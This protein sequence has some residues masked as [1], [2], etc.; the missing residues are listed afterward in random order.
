MS[1]VITVEMEILDLD[2]LA[3][4][5][6]DIGMELVRGQKTYKWW[7]HSVGDY[8]IPTGFTAKDLGKCEHALRSPGNK[9]AYEVGV[10]P[11]R[12][13][14]GYQLI[15]DFYGGGQGLKAVVGNACE[16]LKQPYT[17]RLA[18]RH[19]AS[20]GFRVSTTKTETG[21]MVIKARK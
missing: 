8:P 11:S 1:H 3:A 19:W 4:A 7:G 21:E 15:Y 9:S 20:K 12:T 10:V 6:Q 14:E 17:T 5:A 16:N 2:A 13:G 18:E